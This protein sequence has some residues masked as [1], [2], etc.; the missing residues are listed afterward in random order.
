MDILGYMDMNMEM[1]LCV[2][3]Y[4]I[5]KY[6]HDNDGFEM[7]IYMIPSHFTW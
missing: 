2:A 4:N 7:G 3:L 6:S 5:I 1:N